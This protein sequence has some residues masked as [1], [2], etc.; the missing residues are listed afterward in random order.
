MKRVVIQDFL[1]EMEV[2]PKGLFQTFIDISHDSSCRLLE[3]KKDFIEASCPACSSPDKER[4]FEKDG[5][6]YWVCSHCAT[7][8]ISPRPNNTLMDWYLKSSPISEFRGSKEYQEMMHKRFKEQAYHRAEWLYDLS[9]QKD[10]NKKRPLLDIETRSLEY[11]TE[12]KR[13]HLEPITLVKPLKFLEASL[14]SLS[15]SPAI[16]HHLS[17]LA[18]IDAKLIT[19]FDILEHQENSF[20]LLKGVHE[21]LGPDG[22]LVITTRS[23]S[24]FDI[25]VLRENSTIFPIEHMNLIS[26]EGIR[27]LLQNFDFEIMEISTPGQLDVQMIE[28]VFHSEEQDCIPYF[29]QYFLKYRDGLAK[30]RLQQ[31]LQENL[32]S[33]HLRIVAKKCS[34]KKNMSL[35]GNNGQFS[36]RL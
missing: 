27:L 29:L 13:H 34:A 20:E 10:M 18:G 30:N 17:D 31:F 12:L 19:M 14:I 2:H 4:A 5:Y 3:Q 21:A 25:Q 22:L 6:H 26:I 35:G 9:E 11:V 23:G 33:S 24:G 16:T 32:L 1:N 15:E 36:K 28:R 8:F 7:L